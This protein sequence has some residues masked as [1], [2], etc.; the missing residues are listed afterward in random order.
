[1][2]LK[3]TDALRRLGVNIEEKD[4]N[5]DGWV[6]TNAVYRKDT[7]PSMG[8]NVNS[9]SYVDFAEDHF[10][11]IIDLVV[12]TNSCSRSQAYEFVH[13]TGTS[14]GR[15]IP[16]SEAFWDDQRTSKRESWKQSLKDNPASEIIRQAK[17]YDGIDYQ[18]LL[19]CGCGITQMYVEGQQHEALAL[20]YPTGVQFYTRTD[21]GKLI[22]MEKGSKPSDSFWTPG[23]HKGQ[24]AILIA[25]SPREAMLYHQSYGQEFYVIS[26]ISGEVGKISEL[27]KLFLQS[28][29]NKVDNVYISFDRDTKAAE[30]TAFSFARAIRDIDNNY[31]LDVELLNITKLTSGK[32][33][34]FTDLMKSSYDMMVDQLFDSSY[35]Y[36][37]YVWNT[38]THERRIWHTD[39]KGKVSISQVQLARMLKKDGFGKIYYKESS[40]PIMV[41]KQDN[42]LTQPSNNQ[43]NDFIKDSYIKQYSK[44]VDFVETEKGLK[45]V[46]ASEVED[47]YFSYD[48]KI[49]NPNYVAKLDI[50]RVEFMKDTKDA[51]YIYFSSEVVKITSTKVE[52]ISYS[53]LDGVIWKNQIND[54]TFEILDDKGNSGEFADFIGKVSDGDQLRIN[55]LQSNIGYLLH[56]YKNP[57]VPKAVIFID[58]KLDPSGKA[59]G[60]TGKGIV[61]SSIGRLRKQTTIDGKIYET[62]NRF[63]Y[64]DIEPGDQSIFMDDV[65]QGMEF[66]PF[67]PAITNDL[68][69]EKK[70]QNRF[71]I[72]FDYS[73]KFVFTT[74]YPFTDDSSSTRRRQSIVEFAPY[75][76]ATFTPE[77]EFGH[78]FFYDWDESEWN[79]FDNYMVHCVQVYLQNGLKSNTVN[80]ERKQLGYITHP[81]FVTWAEE[82]IELEVNYDLRNLFK[83]NTE[84]LFE[85]KVEPPV[86]SQGNEFDCFMK[87]C[88]SA[89]LANQQ[90]TF[91]KWMQQFSKYKGWEA[92]K[93]SSN[94]R[95]KIIFKADS[96][97]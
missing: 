33:K 16:K 92:Y 11:S 39:D 49:M 37:D 23:P 2:S 1:M 27:Q 71:S 69:V 48:T 34:D 9:G 45:V 15:V 79:Q 62:G 68:M 17:Q 85:L 21:K 32:C 82:K 42:V 25:K 74:N 87:D 31:G 93:T 44:I 70:G 28:L 97:N 38:T 7:H 6:L 50:F 84:E 96:Q 60:G 12:R 94:G 72:P 59:N 3:V 55:A 47:K 35:S 20:P 88:P 83:G 89:L 14:K 63:A 53:E 58:E 22:R 43:L 8:V 77:M 81:D 80:Y 26:I 41:R 18:T 56:T 46:Y 5:K 91:N 52:K 54:R 29:L 86:D 75:Y 36:S 30:K 13:G 64:Q 19:A 61:A 76:S 10:G 51:C 66:S 40:E 4:A 73:P 24:K 95:E 78:N 65:K 57:A 90:T 67:Y